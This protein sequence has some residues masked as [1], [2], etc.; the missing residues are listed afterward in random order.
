MFNKLVKLGIAGIVGFTLSM[1]VPIHAADDT[2]YGSRNTTPMNQIVLEPG[3]RSSCN[4]NF[5]VENLG[6]NPAV[7]QIT[8]GKDGR[9]EDRIHRW[10]K[11]GYDLIQ[12][13]SFAKQLGKTVDIDDVAIIKNMSKDSKV[14]IHC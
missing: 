4:S 13:L 14:S 3:W 1:A 10:D 6:E 7:I 12:S 9:I 11:R 5:V 8:L 2:G